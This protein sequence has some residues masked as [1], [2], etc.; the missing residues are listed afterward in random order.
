M[1]F[2]TKNKVSDP[3]SARQP[4]LERKADSSVITLPVIDEDKDLDKIKTIEEP[5]ED[6]VEE[7]IEEP[8]EEKQN[9]DDFNKQHFPKTNSELNEMSEDDLDNEEQMLQMKIN[10]VREDKLR[11]QEELR[12]QELAAQMAETGQPEQ[13]QQ[14]QQSVYLSESECLREILR[15]LDY[16]ISRV[17]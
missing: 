15:K 12:Q 7:P 16:L 6:S 17:D 2:W 4:T 13:Y 9:F 1:G 8:I 14:Y 5:I 11:K 3:E 10:K